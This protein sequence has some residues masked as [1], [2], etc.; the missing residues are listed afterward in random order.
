MIALVSSFL[1]GLGTMLAVWSLRLRLPWFNVISVGSLALGCFWGLEFFC[2]PRGAALLGD[3]FA[4]GITLSGSVPLL[5]IIFWSGMLFSARAVV[6]LLLRIRPRSHY[7]GFYLLGGA[8]LLAGGAG[9][10]IPVVQG[11]C[12]LGQLAATIVVLAGV[13]I[14]LLPWL[15]RKDPNPEPEDWAGPI[16]YV[17]L[18]LAAGLNG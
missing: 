1:V 6:K 7:H 14:V 10:V 8:A 11:R 4:H 9:V 15:I 13:Q 16:G 18:S 3:G 5:R 17:V 2:W 12:G